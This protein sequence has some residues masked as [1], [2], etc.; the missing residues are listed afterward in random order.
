MF[1]ALDSALAATCLTFVS[2]VALNSRILDHLGLRQMLAVVRNTHAIGKADLI[3]ND[4]QPKIE[5]GPRTYEVWADGMLL[6]CKPPAIL[7][8]AERYFLS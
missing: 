3:H 7:P 1:G 6:T 8:V 4:Y 5:V 2:T